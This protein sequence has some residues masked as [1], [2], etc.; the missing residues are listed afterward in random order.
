MRVAVVGS[1]GL[2]GQRTMS[3]LQERGHHAVAV[4]RSQGQDVRTGAGL[5]EVLADVDAVIDLTDSGTVL[6]DPSVA[7][8]GS[9]TSALLAAEAAAGVRHHVVVSR[10][11]LIAAV[12]GYW[13]AKSLQ[14][15]LI[16]LSGIPSTVLP[17]GPAFETVDIALEAA[18][19]GPLVLVPKSISRPLPAVTIARAL[20]TAAEG[21][22]GGV[23]PALEGPNDERLADMVRALLRTRGK[24][25]LIVEVQPPNAY[26]RAMARGRLRSPDENTRV[27]TSFSDWLLF[28]T[29][30]LGRFAT[31][32]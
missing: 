16:Q 32:S 29:P 18:R 6:G 21:E 27:T 5:A 11:N 1:S 7:F 23:L 9:A 30:K 14:L 22:P 4:S 19:I 17:A 25:A 12:G 24:R 2:V 8:F 15:Q 28:D 3:V 20:V 31:G 13:T 26:W 10:P